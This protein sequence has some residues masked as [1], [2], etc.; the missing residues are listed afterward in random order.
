M[1]SYRSGILDFCGSDISTQYDENGDE[2][3]QCFMNFENG[4]YKGLPTIKT[5]HPNIL[6]G[7]IVGKKSWG[8]WKNEWTDGIVEGSFSKKEIL[9]QFTDNNIRIPESLMTDFNNTIHKKVIKLL[10]QNI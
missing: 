7:V 9:Q 5:K 8:L 3:K 6:K 10:K 1:K 4:V 2:G